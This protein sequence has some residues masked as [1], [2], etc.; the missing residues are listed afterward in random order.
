M[1][2]KRALS[3]VIVLIILVSLLTPISAAFLPTM[4]L[5]SA[6]TDPASFQD[7]AP[8]A[9]S[10]A[11]QSIWADSDWSGS[12]YNASIDIETE[13]SPG[14]LVLSSDID[15]MVTLYSPTSHDGIYSLVPYKGDLALSA[16]SPGTGNDTTAIFTCDP[17]D[18]QCTEAAILDEDLVYE[19]SVN[20][21]GSRLYIPG[22]APKNIAN[23][24]SLYQYNGISIT[25][26]D[27]AH[28]L[29]VSSAVEMG[30]KVFLTSKN[31][32]N[33]ANI[34]RTV[35]DGLNWFSVHN[36]GPKAYGRDIYALGLSGDTL[37]AQ[38]DGLAN[39][40]AKILRY[41]GT[42]WKPETI[43]GLTNSYGSFVSTSTTDHF[44]NSG[45]LFKYTG[46]EWVQV[47]APF[48]PLVLDIETYD[49]S[50]GNISVTGT[51]TNGLYG[52]TSVLVGDTVVTVGGMV[53]PHPQTST[54]LLEITSG[55]ITKASEMQTPRAYHSSTMLQDG[56]ILVT[57]GL[58]GLPPVGHSATT[59]TQKFNITTGWT[60]ASSLAEGRYNHSATLLNDGKVLVTGGMTGTGYLA[61]SQI[62]DPG[63]N[64]WGPGAAM[65]GARANHVALLLNNG[66]VL[67][68]GGRDGTGALD[69]AEV[70]VPASNT[71]YQLPAIPYAAYDAAITLLD[72]GNVLLSGGTTDS[73]T[74]TASS[75]VLDTTSDTWGGIVTMTSARF[76]HTSTNVGGGEVVV[77]GGLTDTATIP[78]NG[79]M[80]SSGSWTQMTTGPV[81]ARFGHSAIFYNSSNMLLIGGAR[82]TFF[83][84]PLS[85]AADTAGR[86]G[87]A[88]G[89]NDGTIHLYDGAS[90]TSS[91]P[92]AGGHEIMDLLV[93]NGRVH[94][95]TRAP[96]EVMV[97]S[98][99][100]AG[101]MVSV[102][103]KYGG[104]IENGTLEW[105]A[106]VPNG[107]ELRIQIKSARDIE[108]LSQAEFLGPDG[109]NSTYFS[110]SGTNIGADH[111]GNNWIQYKIELETTDAKLTPVVD[112]VRVVALTSP[113]TLTSILVTPEDPTIT[114]DEAVIFNATGYDQF[115][116]K[117]AITPT[118]STNGGLMNPAT[119]NY[120]PRA[121]G[122]WKVF[123]RAMGKEGSTNVTVLPG[124]LALVE[125]DPESWFGS[126][127][128]VKDF[129]ALG[130][131]QW[132]NEVVFTPVWAVAGVGGTID[133]QGNFTPMRPGTWKIYANDSATG[134]SGNATA[135]V[136]AGEP[137]NIV[138]NPASVTLEAGESFQFEALIYDAAG[139]LL[140]Q[141]VEWKATGGGR[142][143]TLGMYD[144]DTIGTYTIYANMSL[145]SL[146]SQATVTV[147]PGPLY[148]IQITPEE[149]TMVA[150]GTM[151]FRALPLDEYGNL[152][153]L[154]VRWAITGN[155]G[156]FSNG[157]YSPTV[158]GTY[159]LYANSSGFSGTT[160]VRV[161]PA[162]LDHITVDTVNV[163]LE[164]GNGTKINAQPED[165]FGNVIRN[166]TLV[167]T[168]SDPQ[169]GFIGQEGAFLSGS[170]TMTGTITITATQ[171]NTTLTETIEVNIIGPKKPGPAE[172]P[173]Y[174]LMLEIVILIMLVV[175]AALVAA[176]LL[177][178]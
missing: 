21:N 87:L 77:L 167:W 134:I 69:T 177:R 104:Y 45:N 88:V 5:R 81:E 36:I 108:N 129:D 66:S 109:S 80:F 101:E 96:A 85:K 140:D 13:L 11:Q 131:D 133:S 124:D 24:G 67:V 27:I 147:D 20:A 159:T 22:A 127:D 153:T 106:M 23:N 48:S 175:V 100:P 116:I 158:S 75:T 161:V 64:N 99:V 171:K 39:E 60:M 61:T 95:A 118:W 38:T 73:V 18:L 58:T 150:G 166:V 10:R 120:S 121:S 54:E 138:I 89:S 162:D 4:P 55:N 50:T 113:L 30:S 97:A 160:T 43:P 35:D 110:V 31:D 157:V 151:T 49:H 146:S 41:N 40:G 14:K 112:E 154:S 86:N 173:A 82:T 149:P 74:G 169:L 178:K 145:Y 9:M 170:E 79:E 163:T 172:D 91:V 114:A 52:H 98:A 3:L 165:R 15:N 135:V 16:S 93:Y 1:I 8:S 53:G 72:N 102:P 29:A 62:F 76:D 139:N 156:S 143:N 107:T 142:I 125:V 155:G 122:E 111:I 47:P 34:Y 144:A 70:Y 12:S 2:G 164:A 168:I 56:N 32:D 132:G 68:A 128:E 57:G 152:L 130:K 83:N 176:E 7:P 37:F 126:T 25:R 123:A 63:S 115:D 141:V 84:D 51:S 174:Y 26:F 105:D 103:Y 92:I 42:I 17:V 148:E 28:S 119:G 65:N 94:V 44:V 136:W 71:W 33:R 59:S 78:S 46:S 19:L 117:M 6:I 137:A 90:W